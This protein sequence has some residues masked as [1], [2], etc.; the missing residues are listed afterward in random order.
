LVNPHVFP[1]YIIN[2]NESET[3][4]S[5]KVIEV[6]KLSE[7]Q[8]VKKTDVKLYQA[9]S[10]VEVRIN[11]ESNAFLLKDNKGKFWKMVL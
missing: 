6:W 1:S 4:D 2:F 9:M 10:F 8:V 5:K 11:K 7:N 3:T